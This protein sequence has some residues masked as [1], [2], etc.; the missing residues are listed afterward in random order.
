M[1]KLT[2]DEIAVIAA[3]IKYGR[4]WETAWADFGCAT[5]EAKTKLHRVMT[6]ASTELHRV[7]TEM[8]E[9]SFRETSK[10]T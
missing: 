3:R 10:T 2:D 6:E 4:V 8:T 5:R 1:C 9:R 7:E